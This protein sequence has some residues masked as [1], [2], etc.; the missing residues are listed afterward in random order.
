MSEFDA[1]GTP[2]SERVV[3]STSHSD[4]TLRGRPSFGP[5]VSLPDVLLR[6]GVRRNLDTTSMQRLGYMPEKGRPE[7]LSYRPK[8]GRPLHVI[9]S[10]P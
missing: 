1:A 3:H 9:G 8:V 7:T 5:Y 6:P 10:I 4:V 2:H